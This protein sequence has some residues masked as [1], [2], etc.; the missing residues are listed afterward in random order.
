[1]AYHQLEEKNHGHGHGHVRGHSHSH[2]NAH[3]HD[4]EA[5]EHG[6]NHN[7]HHG[8]WYTHPYLWK[9]L[10]GLVV[11]AFI[12]AH[13]F[14]NLLGLM[15]ASA[16][17]IP[18]ILVG[19]GIL[20]T[21]YLGREVFACVWKD[22]T[23]NQDLLYTISTLTIA[24]VSI[25]SLLTFLP[26]SFPAIGEA[27][28]LIFAFWYVG[29][30][31]EEHFEKKIKIEPMT[32]LAPKNVTLLEHK[33]KKERVENYPVALLIVNDV[34]EIQP[35]QVIPVDSKLQSNVSLSSDM[36][37][38]Q[39]IKQY[40]KDQQ[41]YAGMQVP[42]NSTAE[43]MKVTATVENSQL[44]RMQKALQQ[45]NPQKA[46]IEVFTQRVLRLFIPTLL[47]LAT[48]AAVM[49]GIFYNVETAIKLSVAI[50]VGAC[51][52]ALSLITPSAVAIAKSKAMNVD[53][54]D[55]SEDGPKGTI[56]RGGKTLEISEKIDAVVFD[57]N[58]TLS[59]GQ[60]RVTKFQLPEG[61]KRK[62]FLKIVKTLEQGSQHD[63]GQAIMAFCAKQDEGIEVVKDVKITPENSGV[64]AVINDSQYYLGNIDLLKEKGI[65]ITKEWQK[66]GA[67]Y[68]VEG[69]EVLGYM[70]VQ[71]ELR[72]DAQQ[73]VAELMRR[74]KEVHICTGAD[75]VT[76]EY[77][78]QQ[79]GVLQQNV[80]AR[81]LPVK[82][83]KD[84]DRQTKSEYIQN[85]QRQKK[86]VAFVGDGG[87]DA[88]AINDSDFG[89][90]MCSLRGSDITQS[91]ADA[92]IQDGRLMNIPRVFDIAQQ[93]NRTIRIS[94]AI[95]LIYNTIITLTPV[96]LA[97]F[98][99]FVVEPW[100]GV[101][102]M[103]LETALVLGNLWWFKQT[104]ILS[105]SYYEA[106]ALPATTTHDGE[107]YHR[108]RSPSPSV[109]LDTQPEKDAAFS[110]HELSKYGLLSP[111]ASVSGGGG[112]SM[113][114]CVIL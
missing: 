77:F 98:V 103:F 62:D 31:T 33:G 75:Q 8:P 36:I 100:M 45:D 89:I 47:G 71:D 12:M 87:N 110:A 39:G 90:A 105:T 86:K 65:N 30:F 64:S 92:I 109:E 97:I 66:P 83:E 1:M 4:G 59:K 107:I 84:T 94:L 60:H 70:C 6:H 96:L 49:F 42:K 114:S 27:G 95:S 61:K 104:Q 93:T 20:S 108:L 52:C 22:R 80:A 38:G 28:A 17:S 26:I 24:I 50:L 91:Y 43:K 10:F 19:I 102:C 88:V 41:V 18:Y 63:V 99:H 3:A 54:S 85:L 48:L 72:E 16:V 76:A 32:A 14:V 51:P 74:G 9:A 57:F 53:A 35:G 11:G 2:G 112:Q 25:L 40:T 13:E 29:E 73:V 15:G 101:S 58:G 44:Q 56:L 7:H 55:A 81:C 69:T 5:C 79:L 82:D 21:V 46:S 34:I 23:L 67:V 37:D 106:A 111:T 68:L 78:A 113:P